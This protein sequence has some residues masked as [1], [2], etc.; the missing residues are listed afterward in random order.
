M[1]LKHLVSMLANTECKPKTLSIQRAHLFLIDNVC[2]PWSVVH[3]F[4]ELIVFLR[5]V[6]ITVGVN[7]LN[8]HICS[9]ERD[10]VN[11]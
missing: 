8:S 1:I 6:V 4:E 9:T 11:R 10:T 5:P 3:L 7:E 2:S